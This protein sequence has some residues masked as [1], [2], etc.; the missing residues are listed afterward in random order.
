MKYLPL[1]ISISV[2]L[3]H[4]LLN[5]SCKYS[6]KI[7][8]SP[9]HKVCIFWQGLQFLLQWICVVLF[10]VTNN[11]FK[12]QVHLQQTGVMQ[13]QPNKDRDRI[14]GPRR[15]CYQAGAPDRGWVIKDWYSS[16]SL[17]V[18]I[19]SFLSVKPQIL[20]CHVRTPCTVPENVSF[21]WNINLIHCNLSSLHPCPISVLQDPFSKAPR[22]S[23]SSLH[24]PQRL[25]ELP[26]LASPISDCFPT[27]PMLV[28]L[29]AA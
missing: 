16:H 14:S 4:L 28:H 17:C 9:L 26:N 29:S 1:L 13:T 23:L 5:S 22:Q 6:R 12:Q 27:G 19:L 2:A 25:H 7:N 24:S 21:S 15:S 8:P 20:D 11:Y 3:Q 10:I 18:V